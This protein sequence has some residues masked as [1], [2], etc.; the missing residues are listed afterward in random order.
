ME[1]LVD[2]NPHCWCGILW[3]SMIV[4]FDFRYATIL[5]A[6]LPLLSGLAIVHQ[7]TGPLSVEPLVSRSGWCGLGLA[8]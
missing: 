8:G 4:P 5:G 6:L 7:L 2:S 3:E 1:T